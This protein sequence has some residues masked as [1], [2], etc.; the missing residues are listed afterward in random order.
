MIV[1]LIERM[2]L[3]DEENI[4][5]KVRDGAAFIV[6]AVALRRRRS[7][8]WK[9]NSLFDKRRPLLSWFRYTIMYHIHRMSANII[10]MRCS[11]TQSTRTISNLPVTQSEAVMRADAVCGERQIQVSVR[12]ADDTVRTAAAAVGCH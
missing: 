1:A 3:T 2:R 8:I 9:R 5:T 4:T 12:G 10:Y 7:T 11:W 6:S